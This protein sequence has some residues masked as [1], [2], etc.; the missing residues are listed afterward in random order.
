M[1]S[2]DQILAAF[3]FAYIVIIDYIFWCWTK[4]SIAIST[5]PPKLL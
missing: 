5:K 4:I 1:F 3:D 2:K